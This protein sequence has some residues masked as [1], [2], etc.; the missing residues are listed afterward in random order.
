MSYSF[1]PDKNTAKHL[2]AQYIDRLHSGY[3]ELLEEIKVNKPEIMT[4]E[5][6]DAFSNV[7]PSQYNGFHCFTY[8]SVLNLLGKDE[9][10]KAISLMTDVFGNCCYADRY[11][12]GKHVSE[13]IFNMIFSQSELPEDGL[14]LTRV[15]DNNVP[16][17]VENLE[18]GMIY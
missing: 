15:N 11:T 2:H 6:L 7:Q 1:F 9:T 17:L 8:H 5:L 3:L 12:R 14:N 4:D 18:Q 10:K 16:A 13:D